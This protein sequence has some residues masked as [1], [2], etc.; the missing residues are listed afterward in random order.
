MES[1]AG[2]TAVVTGASRGIGAAIARQLATAGV[3]VALVARTRSALEDVAAKIGGEAVVVECDVT[4]RDDVAAAGA[5]IR[6]AFGGAPDIIVNNAGVF[7]AAPLHEMPPEDFL[8]SVGTNLIAPF[9][10]LREFLGEMRKRRSG[11]VVTIGSLGDR[12]IFTENGAYSASKFGLRAMHEVLRA[13]L[14]GTGVRATLISPSSVNT[15]LWDEIDTESGERD[16]P[17]RNQMLDADAVVRAVLFAL[18]QP[19]SVNVDELRLSRT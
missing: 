12:T 15:A 4:D 14:K 10:V 11:H 2:R 5:R 9:L 13:E 3:R 7:R 17:A 8:A 6:E 1:L 16:F 19:K 18:T